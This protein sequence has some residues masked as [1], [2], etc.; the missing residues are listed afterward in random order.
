M[1][2][3][4]IPGSFIRV[5]GLLLVLWP[6]NIFYFSKWQSYCSIFIHSDCYWP[7]WNKIVKCRPAPSW[8]DSQIKSIVLHY[9]QAA[10][11]KLPLDYWSWIQL[12]VLKGSV[13]S[14]AEMLLYN[15][16][17]QRSKITPVFNYGLDSKAIPGINWQY[18][19][20]LARWLIIMCLVFFAKLAQSNWRKTWGMETLS[21]CGNL[22]LSQ[23]H[24]RHLASS[25][26][27][28]YCPGWGTDFTRE[29]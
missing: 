2:T 9:T 7:W 18:A 24:V 15:W 28:H 25:H 26:H 14:I 12:P 10:I 17:N 11:A 29:Q 19:I 27:T 4:T 8:T 1:R 20:Q 13:Q 23:V 3:C 16:R 5:L 6:W 21:S 22:K